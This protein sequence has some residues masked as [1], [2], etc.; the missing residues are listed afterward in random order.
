[1]PRH[2]LDLPGAGIEPGSPAL[3][4]RFF[5]STGP[6]GESVG[7]VYGWIAQSKPGREERL[8]REERG[9]IVIIFFPQRLASPLSRCRCLC[10]IL[11]RDSQHTVINPSWAPQTRRRKARLLRT[12]VLC[13]RRALWGHPRRPPELPGFKL[14]TQRGCDLMSLVACFPQ[15]KFS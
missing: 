9:E 3:A 6:P 7:L 14:C 4:G 5:L 12:L 10:V 11:E 1:M 13:P 2:T 15:A 8:L